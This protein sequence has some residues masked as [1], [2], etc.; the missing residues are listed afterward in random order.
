MT[1]A[2]RRKKIILMDPSTRLL[3]LKKDDCP[4][5]LQS[6]EIASLLLTS[7]FIDLRLEGVV[8]E[9]DMEHVSSDNNL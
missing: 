1:A 3:A 2:G 6:E 4:L 8:G 7:C 9:V 5:I